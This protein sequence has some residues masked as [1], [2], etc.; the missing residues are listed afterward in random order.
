MAKDKQEKEKEQEQPSKN[1]SFTEKVDA[2]IQKEFGKNILID[3][4]SFLERKR[5]IV[6]VSP[7]FDLKLGG[8]I[9]E[10]SW[11]TLYGPE[12]IGK[13]TL[14][15]HIAKKCQD[16]GKFIYY[17][18]VEGR[19]KPMN[20]N[21]IKGLNKDKFKLI[22]SSQ[23]NILS[24]QQY[25]NLFEH[26][27]RNHPGCVL[28]IDSSAA[29][30][31]EKEM[32]EGIGTFTRG[33]GAALLAQFCRQM[34][35]V[36]P[37]QNTIIINI[38][39]LQANTSGYGSPIQEKGGYAIKYQVDVKLRAKSKEFWKEGDKVVGQKV[40]WVIE[41][42]ALGGIPTQESESYLRYG[43]GIDEV[44]E[45]IQLAS[46]FGL[47]SKGGA[48]MYLD[49]MKNHLS[50]I[51]VKNWEDGEKICKAHG[52]AKLLAMI[53]DDTQPFRKILEKEIKE[54]TI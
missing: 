29:L 34:S 7:A 19:I 50:E 38:T 1:I 17:G 52:E 20:L 16:L 48:W 42:T 51:N 21:G 11:V 49:F 37:I 41:C 6:P 23:E 24:A 12:K 15:L 25:L 8:G 46:D 10:G 45:L 9:P 18:D 35:N 2:L 28:I 30:C 22:Q 26:I 44:S 36:V 3:V 39:Q 5:I 13:T 54:F 40:T 4:K 53:N 33:G 31:H 43:Y 14:A 32:T 27:I 47:I